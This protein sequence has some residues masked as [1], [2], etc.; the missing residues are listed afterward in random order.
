MNEEQDNGLD[1][2]LMK[3]W[4]SGVANEVSEAIDMK[5][6]IERWAHAFDR[7]IFWRNL[8]E[9]GAGVVVLARSGLE[10][11]SGERHWTVQLASVV[12]TF[13]IL[14]YLWQAHRRAS[15]VNPDANAAEY[16]AAL[17]ARIDGQIALVANARYWYVLPAWIFFV[18]V[19]VTGAAR[20][21]SAT[22]IA[23]LGVEFLLGTSVALLIVWLNERYG[24]RGL[25]KARHRLESLHTDA[26]N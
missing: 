10:F 11:A 25:Q 24:V 20:S 5:L 2:I 3:V 23:F 21:P 18:V 4:Q 17:L 8:I 9:Y 1:T 19:F 16:R 15:P 12:I 22:R 6:E 13:F 26:L 14:G 7:R